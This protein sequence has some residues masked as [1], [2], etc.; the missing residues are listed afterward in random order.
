[1]EKI[2]TCTPIGGLGNQLFILCAAIAYS[3]DNNRKLIIT[4][5]KET[6]GIDAIS[7][8]YSY[9]NNLFYKLKP[10]IGLV[11]GNVYTIIE[12]GFHY[13]KLPKLNHQ[14]VHLQGYF[15]SYKYFEHHMETIYNLFEFKKYQTNNNSISLHFRIGDYKINTDFHP[16]LNIDYYINS[17]Q[18]IYN[19][20]N[21]DYL[22]EYAC[23]NND[24]D[25]VNKNII[26]LMK[27]FPNF[28]FKRIDPDLPDWKLMI[29][30]SSCQHN[31]IAN[32]TFSWWGAYIN[33]N[34]YKIVTY[35]SA[36]FGF[37]VNTSDL[38]PTDWIKITI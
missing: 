38:F 26:K 5:Y 37:N 34:K 22:V 11:K 19:V 14:V 13:N 17:L 28:K 10:N 18:Y 15:Q 30:L 4:N 35:P 31:I 23:E 12:N 27:H 29:Y 2:V 36:W 1:M 24:I 3:I 8:R 20:N 25:L 33:Q 7:I 6:K 9:I 32:S 21:K 16:I